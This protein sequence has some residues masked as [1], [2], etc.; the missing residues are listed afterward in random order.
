MVKDRKESQGLRSELR[1]LLHGRDMSLAR[2]AIALV[3]LW[4]LI[5]GVDHFL[6]P[7]RS[8]SL[9]P[10]SSASSS[11]RT[12][13]LWNTSSTQFVLKN[14][15]LRV[16]T[17]KWNVRH[18]VLAGTLIRKRKVGWALRW[19]YDIGC[20]LGLLGMLV[21]LG[22]LAWTSGQAAYVLARKVLGDPSQP[23]LLVTRAIASHA[24]EPNPRQEYQSFIKPLVSPHAS[25][26]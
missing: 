6:K 25:F 10:S 1:F 3:I 23:P 20:L 7:S 17:T 19:F 11:R 5:H 18:D 13:R 16:Q 2:P 22:V 9:L 21:G 12:P 24:P 4:V 8:H 26:C 14:V 15:Y